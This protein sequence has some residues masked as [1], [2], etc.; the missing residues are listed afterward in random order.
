MVCK[1]VGA[2]Q[3]KQGRVRRAHEFVAIPLRFVVQR[4]RV[5]YYYIIFN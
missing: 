5:G 4:I 2:S 1:S 3:F